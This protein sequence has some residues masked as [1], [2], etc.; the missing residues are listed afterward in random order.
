[1]NLELQVKLNRDPVA[2]AA[3][4]RV[5][6]KLNTMKPQDFYNELIAWEYDTADFIAMKTKEFVE[7][8]NDVF[9][10]REHLHLAGIDELTINLMI[11]CLTEIVDTLRQANDNGEDDVVE[12]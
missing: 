7:L 6:I 9:Y 12:S 3:W 5:M 10:V 11:E 1:M 8:R 4:N 2:L